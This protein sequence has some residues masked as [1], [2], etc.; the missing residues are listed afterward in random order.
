[1]EKKSHSLPN[2]E[3]SFPIQLTGKETGINW[4]GDFKYRRPTLG[5]RSRIAALRARLNGDVE[6]I[7]PEVEEFNHA[8]SYLRHTLIEA[9]EWWQ[10]AAFGLELYDGNVVSEVYN[11]CMEFEAEWKKKVHGGDPAQVEEGRDAT[12]KEFDANATGASQG[13]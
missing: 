11:K 12:T 7:D 1:M 2:M 5:A 10:N 8:A 9:P 6:T 13:Q 3:F 4:V